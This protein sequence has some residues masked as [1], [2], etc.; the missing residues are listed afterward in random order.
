MVS[1][2]VQQAELALQAAK[3]GLTVKPS[4]VD[5]KMVAL[6]KQCCKG[7]EKK[8]QSGLKQQGYTDA[9]LRQTV[10]QRLL[11]Q[12]LY[13]NVTKSAKATDAEV[14]V[15]YAQN[16]AQYHQAAT[17][18]VEEILVGKNKAA[19]A[20]QLYTQLKAGASFAAPGSLRLKSI[21]GCT[22]AE[23]HSSSFASWNCSWTTA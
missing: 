6:K 13:N 9:E 8:Y 7:S 12:K 23:R 10:R 16:L 3:L 19:L 4:E 2:L 14:A 22:P 20:Q 1:S 21:C 17:R 18:K 15:Y 5:Q 11:E